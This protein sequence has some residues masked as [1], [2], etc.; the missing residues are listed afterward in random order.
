MPLLQEKSPPQWFNELLA[1]IPWMVIFLFA[2]FF[3]YRAMKRKK[4]HDEELRI[5]KERVIDLERQLELSKI[6]TPQR[7]ER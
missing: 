2:W 7:R 6:E 5:S 4:R 3:I 1:T